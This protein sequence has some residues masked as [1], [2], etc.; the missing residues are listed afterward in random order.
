MNRR[1]LVEALDH[2]ETHRFGEGL[3]ERVIVDQVPHEGETQA[4]CKAQ[5][6]IL[7]RLRTQHGADSIQNLMSIRLPRL[8]GGGTAAMRGPRAKPHSH[9]PFSRGELSLDQS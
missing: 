9:G 4:K 5:C 3:V 2:S 7:E 6:G 8:F 1:D